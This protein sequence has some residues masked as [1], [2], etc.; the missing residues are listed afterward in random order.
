MRNFIDI[1]GPDE[2]FTDACGP[3]NP[4]DLRF[5]E[6]VGALEELIMDDKFNHFQS[7][8]FTRN[9][10][11]FTD[12]HENKLIY[13]ELFNA[14]TARLEQIIDARLKSVIPGFSMSD[15]HK[16]LRSR[17]DQVDGDVFDMLATLGDFTVFKEMMLEHRR[18]GIQIEMNSVANWYLDLGNGRYRN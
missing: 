8:F 9:C 15:F 17:A 2:D 3:V 11:H 18:V 1:S 13:M 4:E 7:E 6:I 16:M 14:Y 5:D 12:D 10:H